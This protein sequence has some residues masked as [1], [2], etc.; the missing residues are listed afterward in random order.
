MVAV[1]R[2]GNDE[3]DLWWVA[4]ARSYDEYEGFDSL[5]DEIQDR[6]AMLRPAPGG[7]SDN[8]IGRKISDKRFWIYV[9]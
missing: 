8:N 1:Y 4:G 2:V 5:P 3:G 7:F 9:E 6:V